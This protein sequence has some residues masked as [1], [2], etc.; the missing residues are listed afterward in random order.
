MKN[1]RDPDLVIREFLAQG[2]DELPDRSYDVVRNAIEGTHQRAIFGPWRESLMSRFVVFATAA[3]A[4]V[5]AVLVGTR[6]LPNSG[7]GVQ[8]TPTD[9]PTSVPTAVPTQTHGPSPT[10]SPVADPSGRLRPGTYA[11]HPFDN[12]SAMD[13][14]RFTFTV[15]S[16]NWEAIG[17]PGNTTGIVWNDGSDDDFG[18][19]FG[20][21]KVHSLN[22]DACHWAT[23]EDIAIGP[24]ALDLLEALDGASTVELETNRTDLVTLTLPATLPPDCDEGEYRIWNAEGFDI[25]ALEPSNI[26]RVFIDDFGGRYVVLL[27]HTPETPAEVI[28]ELETMLRSVASS[29]DPGCSQFAESCD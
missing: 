11:V 8:P 17:E 18:L 26:W 20:F 5:L 22:S 2:I 25:P 12:P 13:G 23:D 14:R 9:S 4:I 1:S 7:V 19:G 15:P 3:A 21:L 29:D 28:N 6:F 27:S 16:R 10:S 24:A